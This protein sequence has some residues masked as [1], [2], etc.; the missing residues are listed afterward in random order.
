MAGCLAQGQAHGRQLLLGVSA[1]GPLAPVRC[2]HVAQATIDIEGACWVC[3]QWRPHW[4]PASCA[5]TDCGHTDRQRCA[6]CRLS[7]SA[8][9]SILP[10]CVE[11]ERMLSKLELRR[12]LQQFEPDPRES[13]GASD[14]QRCRWVAWLVAH[15]QHGR[16][17]R[18][19]GWV[20]RPARRVRRS[21]RAQAV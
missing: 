20:Q 14:G 3:T 16:N 2:D 12:P 21:W 5:A 15:Q 6:T 4:H 7:W 9:T 13:R 18:G 17:P 8:S 10:E 19:S 1:D 11:A